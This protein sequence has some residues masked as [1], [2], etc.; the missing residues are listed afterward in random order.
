MTIYLPHDGIENMQRQLFAAASMVQS[1]FTL[2]FQTQDWGGRQWRYEMELTIT[3]GNAAKKLSSFFAKLGGPVTS[4]LFKDPSI[5]NT[6]LTS[7][8]LVDGA[9]QTG[10]TLLTSGWDSNELVEGD[11]FSLNNGTSHN[12]YQLT[13]DVSHSSGGATL[14]FV[15]SLRVSPAD[16]TSVEIKEPTITLNMTSPIPANITRPVR[17]S[18][19][20]SAI[21]K[22]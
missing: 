11:F 2:S 8:V 15:P 22:L 21:E 16:D 14:T 5:K 19:S 20:F 13:E 4:F 9:G 6:A 10:N 17:Y 7:T 18:F 12:L 3:E 1:P